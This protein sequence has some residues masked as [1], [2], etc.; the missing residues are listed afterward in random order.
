MVFSFAGLFRE[1]R[2]KRVFGVDK[3]TFF[4]YYFILKNPKGEIFWP[5]PKANTKGKDTS[6]DSG[7]SGAGKE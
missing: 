6:F 3:R 7:P 5:I 4:I 1:S 2:A